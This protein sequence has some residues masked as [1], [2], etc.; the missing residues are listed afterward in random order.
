ML[1][2]HIKDVL[3]IKN[4]DN[5]ATH[6]E[7]GEYGHEEHIRVH[8]AVFAVSNGKKILCPADRSEIESYPISVETIEEK[9]YIFN[10]LYTTEAWVLDEEE[11]GTPVWVIHEHLE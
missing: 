8:N 5:I 3:K 10:N 11:A 4:F 2:K 1:E 7:N 6:N 9:R